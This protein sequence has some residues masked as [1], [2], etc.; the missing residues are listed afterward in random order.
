MMAVAVVGLVL[1][2]CKSGPEYVVNKTAPEW[3]GKN[4]V[5]LRVLTMG[6]DVDPGTRGKW[7]KPRPNSV[8]FWRGGPGLKIM[9][10]TSPSK[11]GKARR[12]GVRFAVAGGREQKRIYSLRPGQALAIGGWYP[13][14]IEWTLSDVADDLEAP[15]EK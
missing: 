8:G 7:L 11:G 2:S 12:V 1:A 15:G 4:I 3:A 13:D 10:D 6:A 9:L 5:R 14:T